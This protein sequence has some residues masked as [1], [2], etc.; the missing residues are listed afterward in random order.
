MN[1]KIKLKRSDDFVARRLGDELLLVPINQTGVDVQKIQH[2]VGPCQTCDAVEI[3]GQCV[4]F[5]LLDGCSPTGPVPYRCRLAKKR[6]EIYG[7]EKKI[8]SM[9]EISRTYEGG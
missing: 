9:P 5:A 8:K 2:D 1:S 6:A 3:C 4:A 7:I